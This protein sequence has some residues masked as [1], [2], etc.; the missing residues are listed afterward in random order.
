MET[1]SDEASQLETIAPEQFQKRSERKLKKKKNL[2]R[3][4]AFKK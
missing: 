3:Q 1:P 4:W 2:Q